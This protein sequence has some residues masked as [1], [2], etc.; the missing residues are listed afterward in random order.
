MLKCKMHRCVGICGE[1]RITVCPHCEH[2]QFLRQLQISPAYSDKQV[3]VQLPC[4]HI[5]TVED[6]DEHVHPKAECE[7]SLLQ[8]PVCSSPL[9]CS[10]RYGDAMKKSLH[11]VN[12][13]KR[14]IDAK[15]RN[16]DCLLRMYSDAG[17]GV[18]SEHVSEAG[19]P[20]L[21]KSF[22]I[23]LRKVCKTEPSTE[24]EFLLFL[25]VKLFQFVQQYSLSE[26]AD[27]IVEN[28]RA[29]LL[30]HLDA[31]KLSFQ[32]IYDLLS[33]YYRLCLEVMMAGQARSVL[34]SKL[35][36][37]LKR[38]PHSRLSSKEFEQLSQKLDEHFGETLLAEVKCFQPMI[39]NGTWM[40]CIAGHYYCIPATRTD[41]KYLKSNCFQCCGGE[42]L[43]FYLKMLALYKFI[44]RFF[45]QVNCRCSIMLPQIF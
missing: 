18:N 33:S 34:A 30:E 9:S 11:D 24:E 2:D 21:H 23:A 38:D 19:P 20:Q 25:I 14:A 28:L 5:F 17:K 35:F 42:Y 36:E 16:K 13:V 44:Y 39:K 6:M 41:L 31:P 12:A 7:V 10:Y 8:C 27:E 45:H 32:I 29:W 37:K 43:F 22:M 40:K 15:S 26:L 3:Y 4:G 1:P